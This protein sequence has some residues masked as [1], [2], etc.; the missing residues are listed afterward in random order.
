MCANVALGGWTTGP[1]LGS[2][3]VFN[4]TLVPRNETSSY[5]L[6]PKKTFT[7]FIYAIYAIYAIHSNVLF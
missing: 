7:V 1:Y 3:H 2:I 5:S 6:W 4:V